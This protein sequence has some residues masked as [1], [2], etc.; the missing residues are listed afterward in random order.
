MRAAWLD[1]QHV[2]HGTLL[3]VNLA[4]F[5]FRLLGLGHRPFRYHFD[6]LA[7]ARRQRRGILPGESAPAEPCIARCLEGT[8]VGFARLR[9]IGGATVR[10]IRSVMNPWPG[11]LSVAMG[12]ADFLF[13]GPSSAI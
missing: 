12:C 7:V 13:M 3:A 5:R 1:V 11:R 9:C 6:E 10:Y 2:S 4:G 8:A